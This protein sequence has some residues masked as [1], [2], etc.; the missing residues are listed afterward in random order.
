MILNDIIFT[1]M[2]VEYDCGVWL[3]SMITD[4]VMK[5]IGIYDRSMLTWL[6]YVDFLKWIEFND[7]HGR[8]CYRS[9]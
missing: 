5:Y 8:T 4:M 1:D 9:H 6:R 3:W 7:I 2:V